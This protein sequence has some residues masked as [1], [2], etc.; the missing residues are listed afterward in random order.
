MDSIM[1]FFFCEQMFDQKEPRRSFGI[2]YLY[3]I[4]IIK[5]I[6]TIIDFTIPIG[7]FLKKPRYFN[8]LITIVQKQMTNFRLI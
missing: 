4:K 5:I 2:I 3:R 6:G 1:M 8:V 7:F